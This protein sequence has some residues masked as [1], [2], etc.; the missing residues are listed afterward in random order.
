MSN[1]KQKEIFTVRFL[2]FETDIDIESGT[3][4]LDAI[5]KADLPLNTTCGGKGTCGD[6]IIQILEGTYQSKPSAALPQ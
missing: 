3:N 2:P 1:R 4:A 5:R 6:C